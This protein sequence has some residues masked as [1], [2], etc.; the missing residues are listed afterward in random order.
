MFWCSA[1][2]LLLPKLQCLHICYLLFCMLQAMGH[3]AQTRLSHGT[4]KENLFQVLKVE[5]GGMGHWIL[6]S[7]LPHRSH[8]REGWVEGGQCL[9]QYNAGNVFPAPQDSVGTTR[10]YYTHVQL[11]MGSHMFSNKHWVIQQFMELCLKKEH[12]QA[13]QALFTCLLLTASKN[14]LCVLLSLLLLKYHTCSE[15]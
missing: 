8:D 12:K 3:R 5:S 9:K 10:S 13:S 2:S 7:V 14:A 15:N 6:L 1:D 11:G 4:D